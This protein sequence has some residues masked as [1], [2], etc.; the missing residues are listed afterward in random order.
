MNT[1]NILGLDTELKDWDKK[2]KLPIYISSQFI[3]KKQ[4]LVV[5]N[6]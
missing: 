3:I 2:K 6:V 1:L 5:L 4:L